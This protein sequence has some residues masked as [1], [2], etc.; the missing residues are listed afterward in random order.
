[1]GALNSTQL[2]TEAPQGALVSTNLLTEVSK[3][4]DPPHEQG[5]KTLLPV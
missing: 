1:M 2:E 4:W 5:L 3:Q